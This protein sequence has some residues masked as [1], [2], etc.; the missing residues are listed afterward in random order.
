VTLVK[1]RTIKLT[2]QSTLENVALVGSS[3][4]RMCVLAAMSEEDA[5]KMELC[6]VEACNNAIEH[7]YELQ[8]DKEV[9]IE[10]TFFEDRV[11]FC[12]ADAGKANQHTSVPQLSYDPSDIENLPEGRMG[13]FIINEVMDEMRYE[14]LDGKN[15]FTMVKYLA[16][17]PK[18]VSEKELQ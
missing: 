5:Y 14:T 12:V 7:A 2:I 8:E 18:P 17:V 6:V 4:N 9:E 16:G 1:S 11:V 15:V 13:L 3:I 10:V